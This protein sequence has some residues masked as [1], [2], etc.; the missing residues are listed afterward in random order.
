MSDDLRDK[1]E[2]TK[3]RIPVL[4]DLRTEALKE[5]HWK[6]ISEIVGADLSTTSGKKITI[7][8]LDKY[9]VFDFG[10]DISRIVRTATLE[11]QL[12]C[13]INE[14]RATWTEQRLQ[15][16]EVH[17][18]PIVSD[19]QSLY[20]TVES[21][22]TTLREL[23][24]SRYSAQMK[25]D[26]L[27]WCGV[28]EKA[29]RFVEVLKSTQ[30]LWM[31]Q[32]VPLTSMAIQDNHPWTFNYFCLIRKKLHE[33]MT[34]LAS[35]ESLVAALVNEEDYQQ[36]K[37]ILL[38]LKETQQS[39]TSALWSLRSD[40]PR[41]FFLSDTMLLQM[42][43]QSH[44]NLPALHGFLDKIFPWFSSLILVEGTDLTVTK[45]GYHPEIR[46][47]TSKDGETV[48]FEEVLKA[49][50]GVDYWIKCIGFQMRATMRSQSR[51]FQ[52]DSGGNRLEKVLD[53]WKNTTLS[54]QSQILVTHAFWCQYL[55]KE[56]QGG[57]E[58]FQKSI[59]EM[60][61]FSCKRIRECEGS[62]SMANREVA[63]LFLL[64]YY[65]DLIRQREA[66]GNGRP[67]ESLYDK[68]L[69]RYKWLKEQKI[70]CCTSQMQQG[71][72]EYGG[73]EIPY[74]YEYCAQEV[75]FT[76]LL[77]E[78]RVAHSVLSIMSQGDICL[79]KQDV[80]KSLFR[81]LANIYGRQMHFV[82]PD[83]NQNF[84]EALVGVI[85]TNSWLFIEGL[86][87][88]QLQM[89]KNLN[90]LMSLALK[91]GNARK[92]N[93]NFVEV[94]GKEID[95]GSSVNIFLSRSNL[96]SL[97]CP[98]SEQG[99]VQ[100]GG[101]ER[102]RQ[103]TV[104]RP[105]ISARVKLALLRRGI[106]DNLTSVY[107]CSL[108]E[109]ILSVFQNDIILQDDNIVED[110][111]DNNIVEEENVKKELPQPMF[112]SPLVD[113]LVNGPLYDSYCIEMKMFNAINQSVNTSRA[114]MVR[115]FLSLG[116]AEHL[117]N[118][119]NMMKKISL[120]VDLVELLTKSARMNKEFKTFF[121]G[122]RSLTLSQAAATSQI[123]VEN[124]IKLQKS[125]SN[126]PITCVVADTSTVTSKRSLN[127]MEKYLQQQTGCA[128]YKVCAR[129]Q[130]VNADFIGQIFE[131]AKQEAGIFHVIG[132]VAIHKIHCLR[133]IAAEYPML[134]VMFACTDLEVLS[135][136]EQDVHCAVLKEDPKF[137]IFSTILP[138]LDPPEEL[139]KVVDKA[140]DKN[141]NP[142][143]TAA[144]E[145]LKT[146]KEEER[147]LGETLSGVCTI[148]SL[149]A[150]LG[151][152]LSR[153]YNQRKVEDAERVEA[154]KMEQKE[155]SNLDKSDKSAIAP[156]AP[157]L[158]LNP[159]EDYV[160]C[161][162]QAASLLLRDEKLIVPFIDRFK[163]T[164]L[165]IKGEQLVSD[166]MKDVAEEYIGHIDDIGTLGT[167]KLITVNP[168]AVKPNLED[169]FIPSEEISQTIGL[170]QFYLLLR[171]S[172]ILVG[173]KGCGK[174]LTFSK[175]AKSF[176]KE[177]TIKYL[178]MTR[179]ATYEFAYEV[180]LLQE[181]RDP[182]KCLIVVENFDILSTVHTHFVHSLMNGRSIYDQKQEKF[183]LL[184]RYVVFVEAS[185]P[186]AW[187]QQKEETDKDGGDID[188]TRES[189]LNIPTMLS[190]QLVP[191]FIKKSIKDEFG[192]VS[193]VMDSIASEFS[194]D[195]RQV[196]PIVVKF[197]CSWHSKMR[198]KFPTMVTNHVLHRV[199]TGALAPVPDELA[200]RTKFLRH[201]YN[202]TISEYSCFFGEEKVEEALLEF[203]KTEFDGELFEK[204][205]STDVHQGSL[206]SY[207][208]PSETAGGETA[209]SNVDVKLQTTG[210]T[211][212]A[213]IHTYHFIRGK[214]YNDRL[215]FSPHFTGQILAMFRAF[216]RFGNVTLVGPKGC[217]KSAMVNFCSYYLNMDLVKCPPDDLVGTR[218]KLIEAYKSANEGV[219][220]LLFVSIKNAKKAVKVFELLDKVFYYYDIPSGF[221][222]KEKMSQLF[223]T[224]SERHE[225][226]L[227]PKRLDNARN[228]IYFRIKDNLHVVI[229]MRPEVFVETYRP[230][231]NLY[232][233]S[234]TVRMCQWSDETLVAIAQERFTHAGME[235]DVAI[236]LRNVSI[237]CASLHRQMM[238]TGV[239]A[240][241]AEEKKMSE[242][243]KEVTYTQYLDMVKVLPSLYKP[244]QKK[245]AMTKNSLQKGIEQVKKANE[246]INKLT[247]DI[248]EKEPEILKLK[249][250]IEQLNKRL[251]QERINLDKAS[252]AFRKKEAAAR[253]K[254]EETQELA[255]DA[256]ANLQVA[257]PTLETSLQGLQNID[258]NDLM[259]MRTMKNPPEIVQQVMEAVCI[260]LGVKSDWSTAKVML[261][262]SMLV[263]K[264]I[265]IDKDNLPDY[266]MKRIR[267]YIDN[268]KF[269]PEEISKVSRAS[270]TFA[271][272]VR[273]I[274]LYA[275][276]F[277]SI[278]PK[279]VRLLNAESELA[280]LMKAL[281]AETDRVAHIE[282]TITNIQNSYQERVKRKGNLEINVQQTTDRLARAQM[283][284]YSLEEESERWKQ[285]LIEVDKTLKVLVGNSI[286]ASMLVA[287]AGCLKQDERRMAVE[288]WRKIC[289]NFKL[290]TTVV[291]ATDFL[292][293][294]FNPLKSWLGR[295]E[296]YSQNYLSLRMSH[297]WPVLL[298]PH[299][300]A[301]EA[302]QLQNDALVTIDMQD[303]RL[304]EVLKQAVTKGQEVLV[305]NFTLDFPEMLR[306]VFERRMLERI[307]AFVGL[308][309]IPIL[310]KDF[311]VSIGEDELIC[312]LK[313]KLIFHTQR[314]DGT[315]K[316]GDPVEISSLKKIYNVVNFEYS[317]EALDQKLLRKVMQKADPEF[318]KQYDDSRSI[319][320]RL[321][322]AGNYFC[323]RLYI[324][325]DTLLHWSN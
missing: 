18:M 206:V 100:T 174:S 65:Q 280:D 307:H 250:E 254:S 79:L 302:L 316:T 30:D 74:G 184:P 172:V 99:M 271:M 20:G 150:P 27:K 231:S 313:F 14:L 190:D 197:V 44:N 293:Q 318:C 62:R 297:K 211:V 214:S 281:R 315:N 260:L 138:H 284:S 308:M 320:R 68:I 122:Q 194:N 88:L 26:L 145:V 83:L 101:L 232:L 269:N 208:Q 154:L 180:S 146:M 10:P 171:T 176:P 112:H 270:C 46:G 255:A 198:Q 193:G 159:K 19:F 265:E 213:L 115:H 278:E 106:T 58:E 228:D 64:Q 152:F 52:K 312:N 224:D 123:M 34:K 249:T 218:K 173:E 32:E 90:F 125:V 48:I 143:L 216:S 291:P 261:Q 157:E 245:L 202:E 196:F 166:G 192:V 296:F 155:T 236:G 9:S 256:H 321:E 310:R 133:T 283:L 222:D 139:V 93:E 210:E 187:T 31:Y 282:S 39:L 179:A 235:Q 107:L 220:K 275:K 290:K 277:K 96:Y 87:F 113:T 301:I 94:L 276:I 238:S 108:V 239:V 186:P 97:L 116:V 311:R 110:D 76:P 15:I 69:I 132:D 183:N 71:Q 80:R 195:T 45:K 175:V 253:K 60:E 6:A 292:Q 303:D 217:G 72:N 53:H 140:F 81:T 29:E 56:K 147:T 207:Y 241:G 135:R 286:V 36:F 189:A 7:E 279:R 24:M 75:L 70:F 137:E 274:D 98:L 114:A 212:Q 22:I 205:F 144:I 17:G 266:I 227:D 229:A 55:Q 4:K 66:H 16:K 287:Y 119:Q 43:V 153:I 322:T 128:V 23:G 120:D 151:V 37:D 47:I 191:L 289:D 40:S 168:E 130:L 21:S 324:D 201:F 136:I 248:T 161:T 240:E 1:V 221:T 242:R 237:A 200:N 182:S 5:R 129:T 89:A 42:L 299:N 63:K 13:L 219:P 141:L 167:A 300:L 305:L 111:K 251:S 243:M 209:T 11:E 323:I 160:T 252:K 54:T 262:D 264:I 272:W 103:L 304:V 3:R 246:Y 85:V 142:S 225:A 117:Q 226:L 118:D 233:K 317:S 230:Y 177:T 51:A 162:L 185:L 38:S 199:I 234:G 267:R 95:L 50:L 12:D 258:K 325:V 59:K 158:L 188:R 102:Y 314:I 78:D 67:M 104:S 105:S 288:K 259:E 109:R 25:D 84:K 92:F 61:E 148:N 73:Y 149:C 223:E 86:E 127:S 126:F 2:K 178:N 8:V 49:R 164:F 35:S 295:F 257:L 41:L 156:L 33:K 263:Q 169:F 306:E 294:G 244:L 124:C 170:I 82:R 134:K 309:G 204:P 319:I 121:Q 273:A 57:I 163:N 285:S 165:K 28:V 203:D 268:P 298:D 181:I 247:R 77:V 131:C 91:I 215:V